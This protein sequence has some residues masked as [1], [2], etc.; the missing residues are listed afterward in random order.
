MATKEVTGEFW[1]RESMLKVEVAILHQIMAARTVEAVEAAESFARF[2]RLSG[3]DAEN[4]PLFLKMLEIENHWVLDA[5]IGEKDP[6]LLLSTIPPNN[7]LVSKCYTLLTRWRPGGIYPKTLAIVLGVLQN[8]YSSPRD[9]YKIYRL[10]IA[11]V[12]NLGKHLEKEK[13]QN[14]ARNRCILDILEKIGSL[15]GLRWDESMEAVAR[16]ALKIRSSFFDNTKLL[17]DCI[18]QVLLVRGDYRQ[19]ELPPSRSFTD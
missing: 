6:F 17:E 19:D 2:L 15:E 16:Q 8:A 18:P 10:S 5:L 7:Y 11:D 14:E 13:G 3:L 12:D 4:Y 1:T 9:G